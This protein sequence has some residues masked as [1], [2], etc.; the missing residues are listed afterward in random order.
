ME[1]NKEQYKRMEMEYHQLVIFNSS[2][3][4]SLLLALYEMFYHNIFIGFGICF[5]ALFLLI[6]KSNYMKRKYKNG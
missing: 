2:I 1:K 4:F 5:I 6:Y 3:F